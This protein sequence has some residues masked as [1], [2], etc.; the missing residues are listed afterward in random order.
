MSY[1]L[2]NNLFLERCNAGSTSS[3]CL[4]DS[5]D[6]PS[7]TLV[8]LPVGSI[9]ETLDSLDEPGLHSITLGDEELFAFTRDIEERSEPINQPAESEQVIVRGNFAG[10]S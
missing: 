3:C 10:R 2:T 6:Y 1:H 8:T 9:I 7:A 5:H 4:T